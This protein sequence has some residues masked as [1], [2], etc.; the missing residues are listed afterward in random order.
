MGRTRDGTL[1]SRRFVVNTHFASW[2]VLLDEHGASC[3]VIAPM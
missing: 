1:T 2:G 3:Y